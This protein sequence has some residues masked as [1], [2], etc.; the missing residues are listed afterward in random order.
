MLIVGEIGV[1]L[2]GF[3]CVCAH[4]HPDLSKYIHTT[5]LYNLLFSEVWTLTL[6][7]RTEGSS[8]K[9][10]LGL[11]CLHTQCSLSG[12]LPLH[13]NRLTMA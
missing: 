9:E 6:S 12:R 7:S 10:E 4:A 13:L 5:G 3:V 8:M 11:L 2:F 1:E